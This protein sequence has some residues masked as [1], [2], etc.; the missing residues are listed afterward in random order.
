[1]IKSLSMHHS[2]LK[3]RRINVLYTQ[4]GKKKGDEKKKE[5]KAKNFKLHAMRKQGK[6]VGSKKRDSEKVIPQG[7]A[8]S[9]Q[10]S[11]RNA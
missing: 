3:G 6:L 2:V 8:E 4:G 7:K 9:R 10:R 11:T 5:I 1:M